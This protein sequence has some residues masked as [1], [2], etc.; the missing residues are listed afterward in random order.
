M[1]CESIYL[2]VEIDLHIFFLDRLNL[3]KHYLRVA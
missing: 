3:T 1:L 2:I